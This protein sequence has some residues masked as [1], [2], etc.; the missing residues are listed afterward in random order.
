MKFFSVQA[1]N[2]QTVPNTNLSTWTLNISIKIDKDKNENSF[3]KKIFYDINIKLKKT[4]T[5][6]TKSLSEN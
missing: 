3:L 4:K 1:T 2:I 5:V 6:P